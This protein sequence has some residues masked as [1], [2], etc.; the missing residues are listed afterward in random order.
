VEARSAMLAVW[1]LRVHSR[2]LSLL[3]SLPTAAFSA[4]TAKRK[5]TADEL[6]GRAEFNDYKRW[7]HRE[8][9]LK[10][11]YVFGPGAER[12]IV[13]SSFFLFDGIVFCGERL[14]S[15]GESASAKHLFLLLL[16]A[17]GLSIPYRP[18]SFCFF[19]WGR[20]FAFQLY[21]ENATTNVVCFKKSLTHH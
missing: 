7:A 8:G 16:L 13:F 17:K 14:E 5:P 10:K 9:P 21:N 15:L 6:L 4:V 1:S 18:V 12:E 2:F 11:T 20:S 3:L 19:F